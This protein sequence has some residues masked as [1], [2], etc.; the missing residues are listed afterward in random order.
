M[1][2]T[3]R[4]LFALPD[5]FGDKGIFAEALRFFKDEGAI[6]ASD[7]KL[8]HDGSTLVRDAFPEAEEQYGHANQTQLELDVMRLGT[9]Y[10]HH[11]MTQGQM[12]M[13][14]SPEDEWRRLGTFRSDVV[15]AVGRSRK[16]EAI[17]AAAR[18]AGK[19]VHHY[20]PK[21][22]MPETS[23][24]SRNLKRVLI[25]TDTGVSPEEV[26][27]AYALLSDY[28][29]LFDA[30][31]HD[32]PVS[33]VSHVPDLSIRLETGTAPSRLQNKLIVDHASVRK[34]SDILDDISVDWT[35]ASLGLGPSSGAVQLI[36][37]AGE[38]AWIRMLTLVPYQLVV[39]IGSSDKV[40]FC[41]ERAAAAHV[42][43]V[44]LPNKEAGHGVP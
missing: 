23:P 16:V 2:N 32:L 10:R 13:A 41:A 35:V 5:G 11:V 12:L 21:Q 34:F 4:L 31:F 1:P 8:I 33:L 19:P 36:E 9:I 7:F 38:A 44:M 22:V 43:V 15:L 40:H 14:A 39:C 18:A 17:V 37:G 25:I 42:P 3:F 6:P 26:G 28:Y 20:L 27:K 24:L 30:V 29:G